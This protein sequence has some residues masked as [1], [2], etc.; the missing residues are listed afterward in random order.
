MNDRTQ[1]CELFLIV[2]EDG[3]Y[4]VGPTSDA[5]AEYYADD[6]G[7]DDTYAKRVFKL[8]ITVPLPAVIEVSAEL[9]GE[10]EDYSLT[11]NPPSAA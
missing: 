4:S 3:N 2:D 8:Q 6:H 1:E 9:Q 11:V 7:N 10:G 5:A